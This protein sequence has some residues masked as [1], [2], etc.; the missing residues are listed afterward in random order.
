[1]TLKINF[2]LKVFARSSLIKL[3]L[4]WNE[5]KL[6]TKS[7]KF[8]YFS[9]FYFICTNI[10]EQKEV[11]IWWNSLK[12]LMK[13][14]AF[15]NTRSKTRTNIKT[16]ALNMSYSNSFW[17]FFNFEG[18]QN[19]VSRLK[20]IFKSQRNLWFYMKLATNL[21]NYKC[22]PEEKARIRSEL[23]INGINVSFKLISQF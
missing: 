23:I 1:M 14:W 5:P 3:R 19:I 7:L 20:I 6:E 16:D 2:N 18:E 11:L 13:I 17:R 12:K 22:I 21:T 9:M 4:V 10:L 15:Y 8:C